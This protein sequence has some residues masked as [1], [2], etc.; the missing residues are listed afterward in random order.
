MNNAIKNPRSIP[1]LGLNKSRSQYFSALQ[2]HPSCVCILPYT[3]ALPQTTYAERQR[4]TKGQGLAL[5]GSK[6]H[7]HILM[8]IDMLLPCLHD[9]SCVYARWLSVAIVPRQASVAPTRRWHLLCREYKGRDFSEHFREMIHFNSISIKDI[10][11]SS[12]LFYSHVQIYRGVW[13]KGVFLSKV[14]LGHLDAP[15]QW[16]TDFTV[17]INPG[18]FPREAHSSR[19][20]QE[21]SATPRAHDRGSIFLQL[22]KVTQRCKRYRCSK[23]QLLPVWK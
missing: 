15:C 12:A 13:I 21:H 23:W 22:C 11:K 7:P 1:L 6:P 9:L 14:T 19:A 17:I 20:E 5:H 18:H 16:L 3:H 2:V 4:N 10:R 8:R